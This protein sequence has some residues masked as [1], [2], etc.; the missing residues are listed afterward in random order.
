LAIQRPE[1]SD[2]MGFQEVEDNANRQYSAYR[3][4]NSDNIAAFFPELHT[5]PVEGVFSN[6]IGS[7]LLA[8]VLTSHHVV[9]D[10]YKLS[11][12]I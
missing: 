4:I 11:R 1:A 8:D 7:H 10:L 12:R 5:G 9:V 6:T 3:E 2:D